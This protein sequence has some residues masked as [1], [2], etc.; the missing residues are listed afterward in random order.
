MEQLCGYNQQ[1]HDVTNAPSNTA[2]YSIYGDIYCNASNNDVML[3]DE[4]GGYSRG[5]YSTFKSTVLI[6]TLQ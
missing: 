6:F 5:T 3:S 2:I 4:L 1:V